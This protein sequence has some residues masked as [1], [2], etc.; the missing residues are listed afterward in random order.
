MVDIY[1]QLM[2]NGLVNDGKWMFNWL[3]NGW[4]IDGPL[5]GLSWFVHGGEAD[6]T[7]DG[8]TWS[9]VNWQVEWD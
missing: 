3:V 2:F 5:L 1:G 4:L 7:T 6:G 9:T 8:E